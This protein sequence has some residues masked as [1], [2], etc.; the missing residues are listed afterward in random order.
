[1]VSPDP[2]RVP[3]YRRRPPEITH[4]S[5]ERLFAYTRKQLAAMA[6][7][8]GVSGWHDMSK[9]DLVSGLRRGGNGTQRP[10]RNHVAPKPLKNTHHA[11]PQRAAARDTSNSSS[12]FAEEQVERAKFDIGIQ[13]KDLSAKVPKDLPQGYGKDRVVAMVR[14]PYWLH[15]Y[16]ELTH[17]SIQRAEAALGQDWHGAKPILRLYDVSAQD[18]TSTAEAILRD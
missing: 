17:Q 9:E 3:R 14:D 11:N 16:W 15:V 2:R 6:R 18:T 4:M 10:T 13:T 7:K 1:M 12:S 5:A 8:R